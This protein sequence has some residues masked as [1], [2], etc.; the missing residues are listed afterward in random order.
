MK[1]L[2]VKK[3]IWLPSLKE[4]WERLTTRSGYNGLYTYGFVNGMW[5]K[6]LP[7]SIKSRSIPVFYEVLRNGETIMIAPLYKRFGGKYSSFKIGVGCPF[8]FVGFKDGFDDA[9]MAL[10]SYIKGNVSLNTIEDRSSLRS[11]APNN[12]SI[13]DSCSADNGYAIN[14]PDSFDAYLKTLHS[15]MRQNIRT[16]YNRIQKEGKEMK[17]YIL[18]NKD[19]KHIEKEIHA[20]TD[21]EYNDVHISKKQMAVLKKEMYAFYYR[22]LQR[23]HVNKGRVKQWFNNHFNHLIY[24]AEKL[25]TAYTI[26]LEIDGRAASFLYA[27]MLPK[28]D[29]MWIPILSFNTDYKFFSPGVII[30]CEFIKYLLNETNVRCLDLGL[31]NEPYKQKMGGEVYEYMNYRIVSF[32]SLRNT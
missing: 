17:V 24:N 2:I 13:I 5:R 21:N 9:V 12:S 7:Y 30:L 6:N 16:A 32:D 8:G 20:I 15:S 22:R 11:F 25:E 3:H 14:L 10:L 19:G 23:Y 4:K 18:R 1:D 26:I 29:R 27:F 31:G 28:G